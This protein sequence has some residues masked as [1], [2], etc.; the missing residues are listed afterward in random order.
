MGKLKLQSKDNGKEFKRDEEIPEA[1]D[2]TNHFLDHIIINCIFHD[3]FLTK[4]RSAV[5]LSVFKT[6]E[7]QFVMQFI[8]DYYDQHKES[9]KDHFYDLFE[10]R[11]KLIPTKIKERAIELVGRLRHIENS[12]PKYILNKLHDALKHFRLE[13]ASVEFAQM[14]ANKKYDEARAIITKALREPD[15]VKQSCYDFLED[16]EYIER[17]QQG[18]S[19]D[20]RTQ[21][22]C[23]DRLIGGMNF[24]WLVTF[25]G[26]TKAGKTWWLMEMAI[27]AVLQGFNVIFI[28]LEMTKDQ[29]D[30]RFDQITGFLGTKPN[31]AVKTMELNHKEWV[32]VQAQPNTIYDLKAVKKARRNLGRNGGKLWNVDKSGGKFNAL[33]LESTID[34]AEQK[35]GLLF[36]VVI[37]DY[38]GEMGTPDKR[39][40]KKKEIIAANCSLMKAGAKERNQLRITAMQGNRDAM[41]SATLRS[42]QMGDAIEP[43]QIS[44]LILAICQTDAEEKNSIYRIITAEYRHGPKHLSVSLVKDLERGQIALDEASSNLIPEKKAEKKSDREEESDSY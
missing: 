16:K 29:I 13:E 10:E 19:Y 8:Y 44:D 2:F 3:D 24:T 11:E 32:Q 30:D 9:P 27:A 33:D 21:L 23:L 43:A 1:L 42:D 5:E 34:D 28:S 31:E 6:K 40:T 25:L 12:N 17:R 37:V 18:K 4:I 22:K 38:L 7:K 36:H 39:I 41:R 26:A 20:V 14:I 35:S 15:K